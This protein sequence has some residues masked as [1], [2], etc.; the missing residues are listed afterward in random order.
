MIPVREVGGLAVLLTFSV[1]LLPF[2]ITFALF[3]I[4]LNLQ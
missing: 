2:K 4:F 3:S 1:K